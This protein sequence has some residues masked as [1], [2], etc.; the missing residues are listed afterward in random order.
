MDMIAALESAIGRAAQKVF[1]PMQPGD[2]P[3]TYADVSKLHALTGYRPT[4]GVEEGLRRFAAWY[5]DFYGR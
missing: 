3:A 5:A 1:L 4:V 2:V